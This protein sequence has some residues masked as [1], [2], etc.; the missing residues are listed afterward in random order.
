MTRTSTGSIRT[1]AACGTKPF[2]PMGTN[3][4]WTRIGN[5]WNYNARSGNYF[6]YGTGEMCLIAEGL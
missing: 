2:G 4:E 3:V 1:P 5:Y 6:N